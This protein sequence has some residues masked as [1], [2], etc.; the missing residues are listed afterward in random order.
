MA[1]LERA[2]HLVSQKRWMAEIYNGR[3]RDSHLFSLPG[4]Y[5]D[6]V[7]SYWLY[8]I[9]LKKPNEETRDYIIDRLRNYGIQSRPVFYSMHRM[10]PYQKYAFC[11]SQYHNSLSLSKGGI[12][13]PSSASVTID[14]INRVCD[15]LNEIAETLLTNYN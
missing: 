9:Y 8:T 15:A 11:S 3:L 14:E 7:N 4:E 5:G 6:V 1:Q 13:L 10:P 12:S 2:D